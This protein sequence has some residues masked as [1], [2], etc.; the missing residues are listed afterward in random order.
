MNDSLNKMRGPDDRQLID[1]LCRPP[2]RL[3]AEFICKDLLSLI[4]DR[5][6]STA[7]LAIFSDA[8]TELE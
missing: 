6:T 1:I 2:Y 4:F 3:K 5:L 7:Y 8:K